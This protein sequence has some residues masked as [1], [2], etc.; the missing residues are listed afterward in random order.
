MRLPRIFDVLRLIK[1]NNKAAPYYNKREIIEILKQAVLKGGSLSI[2]EKHI[3]NI[4][5]M[6]GKDRIFN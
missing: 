6:L 3:K 4:N 1:K 2:Q 5:N